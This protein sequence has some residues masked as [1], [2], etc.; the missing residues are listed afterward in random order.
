MKGR[1]AAIAALSAAALVAAAPARGDDDAYVTDLQ[2]RGIPMPAGPAA[3]VGKGYEIC[4]QIRNGMSPE[5][6]AN[7]WGIWNVWGPVV[8]DAA[9]HHLCP[10][11]PHLKLGHSETT[12]SADCLGITGDTSTRQPGTWTTMT[13][14]GS[15]WRN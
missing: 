9:Q 11:T 10:D 15:A 12:K 5:A 1:G 6:A 13:G 2:S 7:Q 8:V 14:R 3:A 4:A